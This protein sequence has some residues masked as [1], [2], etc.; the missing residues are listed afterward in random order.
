M[1]T[2]SMT[3][4]ETSERFRITKS[5]CF[6]Y[7]RPII[8]VSEKQL[9]II[10]PQRVRHQLTRNKARKYPG[11]YR[12]YSCPQKEGRFVSGIGIKRRNCV[13]G[14]EIS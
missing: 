1:L 13:A 4:P 6:I 9:S 14:I 10:V 8:C 3:Q 7:K 2:P 5:R 11:L 12:T